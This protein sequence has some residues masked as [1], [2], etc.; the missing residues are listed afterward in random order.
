MGNLNHPV[1][2]KIC[3]TLPVPLNFKKDV[4]SGPVEEEPKDEG[5]Q[6]V[7]EAPA[8]EDSEDFGEEGLL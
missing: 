2:P 3:L 8:A 5:V 4:A 1:R 6:E 7:E